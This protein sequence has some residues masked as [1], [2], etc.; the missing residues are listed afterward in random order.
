MSIDMAQIKAL[1]FDMFGTVTDWRRT[2]IQE[3]EALGRRNEFDLDWNQFALA[4]RAGYQPAMQRVRSGELPWTTIDDLHRMILDD[5]LREFGVDCLTEEGTAQL[6]RV[7]H[8]LEPW[9]DARTGLERLRSRFTLAT[10]SNANIALLTNM[11]KR[12]GLRFD[13]ILSAELAHRYKPD[14]K[15]YLTAAQLLGL[16]P[17][18]V[19]MVAAHNTDLRGAREVG[20]RTAFIYRTDEYGPEQTTDLAPEPDVDVVATDI[21][22][23]ADQLNAV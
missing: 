22:E 6:N 3:G 8:R 10:L 20:L 13:C 16:R 19:M 14:P 23:L 4:W 17:D 9:P 11:T 18:Q 12:A 21:H 1:T 5:I 15:V 2:I 7:W